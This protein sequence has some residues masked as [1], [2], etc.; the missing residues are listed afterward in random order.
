[1]L[2]GVL[3]EPLPLSV[4]ELT[5]QSDLVLEAKVSR[6]KTYINSADTAVITDLAILPTRVLAGTVPGATRTP[7]SAIPLVLTTYGGEVVRDGVTIRAENH[8]LEQL[9]ESGSYLLFLRR[10]RF[11]KEP[12]VYEIYNA[13]AFEVSENSV[14]PLASHGAALY[15]DFSKPYSDVVALVMAAARAE[16][17]LPLPRG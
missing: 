4:D 10:S 13:G 3:G 6:L 1:V 9:K 12:G 5:K 16:M 2:I 8:G 15:K 11:H 7:G 14:R 17:N